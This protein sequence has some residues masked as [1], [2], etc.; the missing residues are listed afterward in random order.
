MINPHNIDC[1]LA[2]QRQ[3]GIQLLGRTERPF[4]YTRAEWT[5]CDAFDEK[6][7]LSVKKEFR[8]GSD[9]GVCC[10]CHVERSLPPK[11]GSMS[12]CFRRRDSPAF[13]QS[14]SRASDFAVDYATPSG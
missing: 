11:T 14:C 3:I 12:S 8:F 6:F 1:R 2:H 7:V 5:V 10:F 9:S 4:T 13:A